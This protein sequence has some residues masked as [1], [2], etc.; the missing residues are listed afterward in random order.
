M[1]VWING[2]FGSG[3]TQTAYELHRR[4]SDSFVFDPENIGFYIRKN[5]P[6]ELAAG[7][8]QDFAMWRE[9]AYSMLSYLNREYGGTV[10]VPMTVVNPSYFDEIVGRL[11]L[12]GVKVHHFA[13][14]ASK[15]TLLRRLRSRGD[16]ARS[17]PSLQIDR[18]LEGL[19]ND[20]FRH[21]LDTER[22]SVSTTAETIAG[23]L[24]LSLRP[25]ERG[26]YRKALDRLAVKLKHI[27]F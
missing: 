7:D 15:E 8:F 25:D 21:H 12:D 22:M 3:K 23:M 20:V 9:F 10:I 2:A 1:I 11:R 18:C 13:L 27:R 16:G 6:K 26:P 17:W 24:G 19:A 5:V 14:M 4:L